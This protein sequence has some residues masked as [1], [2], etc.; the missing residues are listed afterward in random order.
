M[1]WVD[2]DPRKGKFDHLGASN[3]ASACSPQAGDGDGILGGGRSVLQHRGPCG[4]GLASN[5][6]K[7]FDRDGQ[8]CQRQMGGHGMCGRSFQ[9]VGGDA[10]E[11]MLAALTLCDVKTRLRHLDGVCMTL[12][13]GLAC[14]R[15]VWFHG[16]GTR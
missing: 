3:E 4:R 12:H 9:A 2:P 15:Q 11:H 5:V 14:G 1:V 8:T 6:K 7:V 13:K 10:S 16:G